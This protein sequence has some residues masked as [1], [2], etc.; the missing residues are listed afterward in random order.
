[1]TPLTIE[2]EDW[3]ACPRR[4]VKDNPQ[5]WSELMQAFR[6]YQMGVMPDDGGGSSQAVRGMALL[7]LLDSLISRAEAERLDAARAKKARA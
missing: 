6:R 4:T 1:M 7:G 3:W 2:G 5:Y